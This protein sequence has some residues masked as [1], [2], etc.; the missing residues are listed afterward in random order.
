METGENIGFDSLGWNEWDRYHMAEQ[1][2]CLEKDGDFGPLRY[3]N[4][5]DRQ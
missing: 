3:E 5:R 1:G 4:G 2:I